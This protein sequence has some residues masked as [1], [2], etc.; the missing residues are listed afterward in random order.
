MLKLAGSRPDFTSFQSRGVETGACGRRRT[1]Y[2]ATT[3]WPK[4]FTEGIEIDSAFTCR[5]RVL[6]GRFFGMSGG[7]LLHDR[8]RKR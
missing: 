3:V 5:D 4:P 2:G 6:N 7:N 8:L 1:E